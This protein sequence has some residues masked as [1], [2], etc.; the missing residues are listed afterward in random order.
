M[1]KGGD[2]REAKYSVCSTEQYSVS[3]TQGGR[4]CVVGDK[5]VKVGWDCPKEGL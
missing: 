2:G 3:R 1:N 4:R 5:T